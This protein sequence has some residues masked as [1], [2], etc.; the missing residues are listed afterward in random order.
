MNSL[1]ISKDDMQ[2]YIALLEVFREF[3]QHEA[4]MK[5]SVALEAI[6]KMFSG[7][8]EELMVNDPGLFEQIVGQSL[9]AFKVH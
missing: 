3:T 6:D 8:L 5:L 1:K 4:D 9:D 7:I 2:S